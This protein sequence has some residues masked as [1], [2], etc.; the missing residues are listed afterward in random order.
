MKKGIKYIIVAILLILIYNH[1]RLPW[2]AY[3]EYENKLIGTYRIVEPDDILDNKNIDLKLD[4]VSIELT[5]LK[6][7]SIKPIKKRVFKHGSV[8][9]WRFKDTG[10]FSL[11]E[12]YFKDGGYMQAIVEDSTLLIYS[13]IFIG[14]E[15]A[16]EIH[17]KKMGSNPVGQEM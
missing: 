6:T 7:F 16:E 2:F 12:F 15:Q 1:N 17:F 10:D 4:S 3:G 14:N 9:T 11:L 13:P 8:G 5:A